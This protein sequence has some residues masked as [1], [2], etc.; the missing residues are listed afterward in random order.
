MSAGNQGAAGC[1]REANA[2]VQEGLFH[3]TSPV[4]SAH[5]AAEGSGEAIP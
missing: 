2:L 1:S 5:S 4:S 3:R